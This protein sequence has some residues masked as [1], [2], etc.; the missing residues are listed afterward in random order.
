ME[1]INKSIDLI[2]HPTNNG[3]VVSSYY[4][5]DEWA[6]KGVIREEWVFATLPE[7]FD[8]FQTHFREV[9]DENKWKNISG[10]STNPYVVDSEVFGG[11]S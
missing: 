7:M 8:F 2:V 4:P 6:K 10:N 3:W 1:K 5:G 11:G 9:T